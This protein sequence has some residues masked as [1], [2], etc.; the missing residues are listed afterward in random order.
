MHI[1][2]VQFSSKKLEAARRG[3]GLRMTGCGLEV[4]EKGIGSNR[5]WE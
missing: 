4:D 1:L 5:E 2:W 3:D